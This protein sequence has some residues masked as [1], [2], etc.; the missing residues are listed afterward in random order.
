MPAPAGLSA[1]GVYQQTVPGHDSSVI[2]RKQEAS[3][4]DAELGHTTVSRSQFGP[5]IW[6]AIQF[7]LGLK[8]LGRCPKE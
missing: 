3:Y 4:M 6:I 2:G 8:A 7:L 1:T 5:A